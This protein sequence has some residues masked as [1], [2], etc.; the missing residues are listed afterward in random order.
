M[1]DQQHDKSC[2][3]GNNIK[4]VKGERRS[5]INKLLKKVGLGEVN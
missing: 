3:K 5:N 4:Q 1:Q 2:Y